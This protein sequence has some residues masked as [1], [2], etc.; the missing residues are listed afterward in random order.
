M[1]TVEPKLS[2]SLKENLLKYQGKPVFFEPLHGNNGDKLIEMGSLEL[3]RQCEVN[4]VKKPQYAELI[5]LNGG[6]GMTDIWVHGFQTLQSY[7]RKFPH[8]PLIICPSSFWFSKT[9]F[10]ALFR[11]RIAPAFIYAREAYSL[12][13]L[14]NLVFPGHVELGLD[15]DLAFHL[16][17]STYLNNL[18]SNRARKHILIVERHDPESVTKP[19]QPNSAAELTS[20]T[21]ISWKSYMPGAI[22]RPIIRYITT[23][24]KHR[25]LA[26][27]LGQ[28]DLSTPFTQACLQ[29]IWTENPALKN[30]PVFSADI[31]NPELCSFSTFSRLI[32]EAAVVVATRLHVGILAAMLDKPTYIK[33]GSY[34]KIQGIVDYSLV[35][36]DNVWLI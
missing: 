35:D 17:N 2:K 33:S 12:D 15:H 21:S 6:A 1:K 4:L 20:Q 9:D 7:N 32:A 14:Q 23:P 19:Y 30:L 28:Q 22:K 3:L 29:R 34:H 25:A 18:R 24:L 5:V 13:I 27:H 26:K 31:S 16:E 11:D 8:I 10:P 36:R